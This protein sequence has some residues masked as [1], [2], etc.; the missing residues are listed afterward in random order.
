MVKEKEKHDPKQ[1]QSQQNLL[2]WDERLFLRYFEKQR[3]LMESC[4]G[5]SQ[6]D[7]IAPKEDP[8]PQTCSFC[9]NPKID[10]WDG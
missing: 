1:K 9:P 5:I 7:H 8:G 6:K 3:L 10:C 4:L 2:L